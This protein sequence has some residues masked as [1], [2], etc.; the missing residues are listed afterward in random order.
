VAAYFGMNNI[1][2]ARGSFKEQMVIFRRKHQWVM[3]WLYTGTFG[4]FIGLA[5]GF[6][7]LVSTQFPAQDAFQ[8]AFL[9]P[10]VGALIRPVGGWLADRVGGA[11][12]T[13][14]AFVVMAMAALGV[15]TTLPGGG[16]AG[17][18][19]LFLALF[20]VLFAAAGVGNGSTFKMIPSIFHTLHRRWSAGLNEE[21]R[22]EALATADKEAAATLGFSSAVAAFGGFFIPKA[23][24]TAIDL[25]GVPDAALIFFALFY[26]SCVAATWWWYARRGAE[27]EC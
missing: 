4:S 25:T 15:D 1:R 17:S 7:M 19:G 21:G 14:W 13:L 26:A 23:Y 6:P 12:V 3:S 9:G 16:E 20:L 11:R 22:R 5:A 18:Y 8:Y 27:V 2:R 24:G 10:L